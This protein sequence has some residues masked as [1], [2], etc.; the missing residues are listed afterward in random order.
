[1]TGGLACLFLY[2][3]VFAEIKLYTTVGEGREVKLY[4]GKCGGSEKSHY[5]ETIKTGAGEGRNESSCLS[6]WWSV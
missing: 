6:V 4:K 1:M 5:P 2:L 3:V